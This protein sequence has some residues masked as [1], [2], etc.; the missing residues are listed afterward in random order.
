MSVL[1]NGISREERI[2]R[3][4]AQDVDGLISALVKRIVPNASFKF[5]DGNTGYANLEMVNKPSL[6]QFQ[7]E[8]DAYVAEE[9]ASWNSFYD[10][11]E[12]KEA[13]KTR[14]DNLA[15]AR[16]SLDKKGLGG[17]WPNVEVL[18]KHIVKNNDT[19]LL[20]QLEEVDAEVVADLANFEAKKNVKDAACMALCSHLE[21]L[22]NAPET[23]VVNDVLKDILKAIKED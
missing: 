23:V 7:S 5:K 19:A 17:Q 11:L 14:L 3:S 20:A 10:D 18:K 2:A 1:H 12:A 16:L 22:E 8:R 6:S 4:N 13:L 9:I 15:D 21:A